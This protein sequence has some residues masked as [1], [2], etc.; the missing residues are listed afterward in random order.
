M[1]WIN[2]PVPAQNSRFVKVIA[3]NYGLIPDGQPG[4]GTRAWV[5]ADEIQI[6]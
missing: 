2:V 4:A 6:K 5:F 3:K 1:G